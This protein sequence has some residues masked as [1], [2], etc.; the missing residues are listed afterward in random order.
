VCKHK[1]S[2]GAFGIGHDTGEISNRGHKIDKKNDHCTNK[3]HILAT[4]GN[5]KINLGL[6]VFFS[7]TV[8]MFFGFAA[9]KNRR[10]TIF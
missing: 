3:Y 6:T 10:I 2:K 7:V 8:E 5:I 9:V 4:S 1:K